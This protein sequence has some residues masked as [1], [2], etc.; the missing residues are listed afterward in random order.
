MTDL[1]PKIHPATMGNEGGWGKN[2]ADSGGETYKGIARKSHPK[3]S[4]WRLVDGVKAL[5][6]AQ[7]QYGTQA[8]RNW[9][10][11]LDSKLAEL[12]QL[13]AAVLSFYRVN[14]WDANRLGE[15]SAEAVVA[16]IYDHVV[17]AGQRGIM[18]AQLA[19]GCKPDGKLGPVSITA[20]NAA[21]PDVLLERLEDIAAAYR[22]D[23]AHANPSQIQFLTSWLRR[24]GQP[25]SII[26]MVRQAAADGVLDDS[27][28]ARLKSAMATA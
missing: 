19:A 13:Q 28:L 1:F 3:W 26:A 10:K 7:P 20:I 15:I 22:L 16:W 27:E 23:R 21:D 9:V 25:E 5:L 4:G 12:N 18:W 8:Y 11:Y 14:F 24:D 6:T 2:P 17:N